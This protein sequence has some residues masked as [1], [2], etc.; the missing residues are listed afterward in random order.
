MQLSYVQAALSGTVLLVIDEISMLNN[1]Q[2]YMMD[3]R[4][5]QA[6]DSDKE[7]GGVNILLMGDLL[8]LPPVNAPFIF[9]EFK[10][11]KKWFLSG[12]DL[13]KK[14]EYMELSKNCR[15]SDGPE[16]E[17][18]IA[19]GHIRLGHH[20]WELKDYLRRIPYVPYNLTPCAMEKKLVEE[21]SGKTFIVLCAK[22]DEAAAVNKEV[23]SDKKTL[24]EI[25]FSRRSKSS[26]TERSLRRS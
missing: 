20:F 21:N 23:K 15:V 6:R 16:S 2:L 18:A 1:K 26:Q 9:E 25:C 3:S 12:L 5:R 7:F 17:T 10:K 4:L 22:R 14:F 13:W 19:L 8:Q 11:P 24:A